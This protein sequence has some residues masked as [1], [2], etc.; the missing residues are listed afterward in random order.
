MIRRS[1]KLDKQRLRG[2][3]FSSD[4]QSH[5]GIDTLNYT[6][7]VAADLPVDY[8]RFVVIKEL[9]HC[10]FPPTDDHVRHFVG[11]AIALEAH[12]DAL[13]RSSTKQTMSTQND[14]V[15]LWMA[16][17]ALC[18]EKE[19]VSYIEQDRSEVA[20][21]LRVPLKQVNNLLSSNYLTEIKKL[22]T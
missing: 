1:H 9:M 16:L 13:F 20:G 4:R 19:R 17:G 8:E 15:A 22:I 21:S 12:L 10:Y 6:I 3:I 5:G 11:S 18:T 7:I 2:L 14:R